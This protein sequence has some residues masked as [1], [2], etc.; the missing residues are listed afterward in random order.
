MTITAHR[1]SREYKGGHQSAPKRCVDQ[2][3]RLTWALNQLLPAGVEPLRSC[4]GWDYMVV[5]PKRLV[6]H[7]A[8]TAI[9][10]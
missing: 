9:P 2:F 5:M 3:L 10:G 1:A 4:L 6:T 7:S 8:T